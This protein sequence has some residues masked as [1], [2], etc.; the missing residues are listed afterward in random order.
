MDLPN[1]LKSEIG[2]LV[3]VACNK[4]MTGEQKYQWVVEQVKEICLNEDHSYDDL[5]R[6]IATLIEDA[7]LR[8]KK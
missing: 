5:H 8:L 4:D 7:V 1:S 2:K 3:V 6:V